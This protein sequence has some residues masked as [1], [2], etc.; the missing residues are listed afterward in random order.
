MNVRTTSR[1]GKKMYDAGTAT[2]VGDAL[3][4]HAQAFVQ[5]VEPDINAANVKARDNMGGLIA[6][7]TMLALSLELYLK[8]LRMRFG[9]P[10]PKIHELWKLYFDLPQQARESIEK[11]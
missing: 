11:L 7:A 5:S 2:L 1:Q 6:S 10:V 4:A 8:A 9:L 3:F